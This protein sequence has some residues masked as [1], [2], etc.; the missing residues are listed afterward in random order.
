MKPRLDVPYTYNR[1]TGCSDVNCQHYLLLQDRCA[2][3]K[4]S[5]VR[6]VLQTVTKG[7]VTGETCGLLTAGQLHS[8]QCV[9]HSED[10]HQQVRC[11]T[12]DDVIAGTCSPVGAT[13]ASRY[14]GN[15]AMDRAR[16]HQCRD[17]FSRP[18]SWSRGASR[19]WKM[20]LVLV[21]VLK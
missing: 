16:W 2:I 15:L 19:T 10:S 13:S 3:T 12:C 21:L 14:A 18:W 17:V 7:C 1:G 4:T 9:K 20:V 5:D 8:E 6:G 11:V